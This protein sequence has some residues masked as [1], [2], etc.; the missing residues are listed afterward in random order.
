MQPS[1]LRSPWLLLYSNSTRIIFPSGGWGSSGNCCYYGGCGNCLLP[2]RLFP[3]V[4]LPEYSFN[5]LNNNAALHYIFHKFGKAILTCNWKHDWTSRSDSRISYYCAVPLLTVVK[6]KC[7]Y[8]SIL[9]DC[10][11]Y[12]LTSSLS[13]LVHVD[14]CFNISFQIFCSGTLLQLLFTKTSIM[15]SRAC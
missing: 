2:L 7:N 3:P 9:I 10:C 14:Y 8:Y 15:F 4:I 1:L 5:F 12:A 6:V 13:F 11:S